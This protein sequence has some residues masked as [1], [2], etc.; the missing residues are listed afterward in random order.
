VDIIR[1]DHFRGFAGYWEIPADAENAMEGEWKPGPGEDFFFAIEEEL[2][3][4]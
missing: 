1:L 3:E 4:L 2:G